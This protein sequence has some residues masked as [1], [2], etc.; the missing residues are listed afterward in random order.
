MVRLGLEVFSLYVG[1]MKAAFT[2]LP[3]LFGTAALSHSNI[4]AHEPH[5]GNLTAHFENLSDSF[6]DK[7]LARL[8]EREQCAKDQGTEPTCTRENVV[9][10]KE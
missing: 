10:R 4:D 3:I 6:L 1:T 7:A 8:D 2:L 5:L 9:F